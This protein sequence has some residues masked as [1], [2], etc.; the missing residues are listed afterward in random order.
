MSVLGVETVTN[1]TWQSEKS[2]LH[3][4]FGAAAKNLANPTSAVI[5]TT[6]ATLRDAGV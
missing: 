2:K 1:K 3:K 6:V 5:I 4:S